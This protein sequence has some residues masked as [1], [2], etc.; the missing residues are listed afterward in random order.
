[1]L[2][3]LQPLLK[4]ALNISAISGIVFVILCTTFM[5]ICI[6]Q[7]AIKINIIKSDSEND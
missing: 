3:A 1:M 6:F 5:I 7:G 2:S 4:F